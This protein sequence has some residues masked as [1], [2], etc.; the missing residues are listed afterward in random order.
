MPRS[1]LGSYAQFW[2]FLSIFCRQAGEDACLMW[3]VSCAQRD[4]ERIAS[5]AKQ[6]VLGMFHYKTSIFQAAKHIISW[7]WFCH[8]WRA[9]LDC[10]TRENRNTF[11]QEPCELHMFCHQLETLLMAPCERRIL[12]GGN[13]TKRSYTRHLLSVFHCQKTRSSTFRR[14]VRTV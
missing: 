8:G 9:L 7:W 11:G 10:T 1:R 4:S 6:H 2:D 13:N 3:V 14:N 12:L 5:L